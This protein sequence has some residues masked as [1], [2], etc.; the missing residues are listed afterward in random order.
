MKDFLETTLGKILLGVIVV[1]IW[2]VNV[3]NFSEMTNNS[4]AQLVQQIQEIDVNE[5]IIPEKINYR[6]TASQRDPF[7][8][9]GSVPNSRQLLEEP[10]P[11][12]DAYIE[13]QLVLA[14]IFDGMAVIADDKG[15]S[16]F[17]EDGDTF[18]DAILVKHIV[19]DSV[20]L[21]YK[22]RKLILKLN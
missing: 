15:Q 5:L 1:A 22:Q 14:G 18:K 16:Y 8:R 9:I 12:A 11:T 7:N 6:Y 10:A 2:G 20:I 3:V 13:P 19:Q 17:V 4:E 21:E